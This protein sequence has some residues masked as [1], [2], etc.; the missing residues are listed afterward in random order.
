MTAY[1]ASV[2]QVGD[3]HLELR[4]ANFTFAIRINF[5]KSCLQ[6]ILIHMFGPAQERVELFER[7]HLVLV[8]VKLTED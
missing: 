2:K 8:D 3:K 5:V 4:E 1:K 6:L 7:N